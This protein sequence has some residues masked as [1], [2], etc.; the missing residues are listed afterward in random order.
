MR[1]GRMRGVLGLLAATWVLVGQVA[2]QEAPPGADQQKRAEILPEGV[3]YVRSGDTLWAI[4]GRYLDN[5]RLWPQ[6]W[7]ENPFVSNPNMIFP[8]D[9]LVIPGFGPLPKAVAEAPPGPPVSEERVAPPTAPPAEGVPPAAVAEVKKPEEMIKLP[10]APPSFVV[11]QPTLECSGFVAEHR[12]VP[13]VGR[14]VRPLDAQN[15][16][17]WFGDHIFLDLGNRKVQ[18]GDRFQV[19]RP[20]ST[21][22]HPVTGGRVGVKIRTLGTVEIFTTVGPAPR[23]KIVY[24]CED[25]AVGDVL[26]EARDWPPPT[27]GL[28]QSTDLRLRGYIVGSKDD[29]DSLGQGDIVYV[30]VGKDQGIVPGDEFSIYRLSGAGVHPATGDVISFAPVKQGELIV[31]RTS[32]HA[33]AALV[34]GSNLHL[35]VGEPIALFR[36]MP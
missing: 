35:K 6:V 36:K 26:V 10:A 20:T 18:A 1:K 5:P 8:G 30:D 13:G 12:E 27:R 28:T 21:V 4:A 19:V 3:Y 2:A 16:R 32:A 31:I 11:P 9:P 24:N 7:K 23:A 29:A 25:L 33:A 34:T 14:I 17:L 15:I 22:I